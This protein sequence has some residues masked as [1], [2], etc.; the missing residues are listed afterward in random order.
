MR[1]RL[2][3]AVIVLSLLLSMGADYRTPNFLITAPTAELARELGEA[4]E[5]YRRSLALDWMGRELPRW[6]SPCTVQARV[7][8]HLPPSGLLSYSFRNGRAYNW[9]IT[10]QGS[11]DRVLYSVLPHEITHA[12]FATH[13]GKPLPRWADEGVAIVIEQA[14]ARGEQNQK[15]IEYLDAGRT[16]SLDQLFAMHEYPAD[17]LPMYSQGYSLV[18]FLVEQGGRRK[19]V[20]FLDD[21]M[22]SHDWA[23]CTE[24]H[25]AYADL[26]QLQ[27]S[28]LGWVATSDEPKASL[29]KLRL[30][31]AEE[32]VANDRA[33][34]R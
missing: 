18:R 17:I 33:R 34:R 16:M 3:H 20:E 30:D 29:V 28:W 13:F 23:G 5:K 31:E 14:E 15:L 21:G 2:P 27:R 10:L 32:F 9:R 8:S 11:R 4:A 24:R 6:E 26:G 12:V 1:A 19:F 7:A 22:Q 25:Y